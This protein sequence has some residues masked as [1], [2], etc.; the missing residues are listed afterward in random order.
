MY[1]IQILLPLYDN[2]R[3]PIPPG[4]FDLVR[5]ELVNRF[6]G[7]TAYIRSPASGIWKENPHLTIQD[8]IVIYEIMVTTIDTF[9]WR[10][11]RN[12]L[13]KR[14]RQEELIVRSMEMMLL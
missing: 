6:G 10:E 5:Q 12:E 13:S 8:E 2:D 14:F 4:A 11:Y 7:L 1:L 9:W 3:Q